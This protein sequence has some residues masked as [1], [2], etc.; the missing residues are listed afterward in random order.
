MILY[1]DY[2][3]VLYLELVHREGYFV[4]SGKIDRYKY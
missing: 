3:Y 4:S 2:N 1:G